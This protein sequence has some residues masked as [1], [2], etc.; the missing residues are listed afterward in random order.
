M[1][2][3]G[4]E[5]SKS[6]IPQVKPLLLPPLHRPGYRE[7]EVGIYSMP[8]IDMHIHA[9]R[10]CQLHFWVL[11]MWDMEEGISQI[12]LRVNPQESLTQS[13][14]SRYVQDPQGGHMVQLKV[15]IP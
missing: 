10:D 6:I 5:Q 3:Q 7:F 11:Q 13:H 4:A 14:E 9:P 1:G 2:T 8:R 15:I 12:K